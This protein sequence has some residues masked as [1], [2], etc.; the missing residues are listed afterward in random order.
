VAAI[1]TDNDVSLRTAEQLEAMGH[2]VF[3]TRGRGRSS[4][5][6]AEQW[7]TS[8]S[9]NWIFVTHNRKD[10]VLLHHAWERWAI[11]WKI[12]PAHPGVLIIPQ[13]WLSERASLEVDGCIHTR[14]DLLN[15]VL[16][17]DVDGAWVRWTLPEA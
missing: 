5:S 1:Y 2:D 15:S 13:A 17:S 6:D 12:Q 14:P 9:N 8:V 4:A 11:L 16:E 7:T 3:T 10:Y